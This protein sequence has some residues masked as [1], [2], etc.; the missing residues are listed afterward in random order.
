MPG[1]CC[2]CDGQEQTLFVC[3]TEDKAPIVMSFDYACAMQLRTHTCCDVHATF[4]AAQWVC[5]STFSLSLPAVSLN[6]C[7]PESSSLTS[8][9]QR[10]C[11]S[12]LCAIPHGL[13]T[14]KR[15]KGGKPFAT[16]PKPDG[17]P[18][19]N[20]NVSHEVRQCSCLV[21]AVVTLHQRGGRWDSA[22]E[23]GFPAL[24]LIP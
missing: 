3:T 1:S 4:T 15:T 23:Q 21:V 20:Y 5:S 7:K 22:S 10:H 11:V 16:T 2:Q 18:N 17:A 13:V 8:Q 19:L 12:T 14:L 6:S 24:N 9:F